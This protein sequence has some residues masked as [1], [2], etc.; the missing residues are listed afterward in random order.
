[1]LSDGCHVVA[2]N[3]VIHQEVRA[4]LL[5]LNKLFIKTDRKWMNK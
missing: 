1:M 3:D 4:E 2:G 5:E